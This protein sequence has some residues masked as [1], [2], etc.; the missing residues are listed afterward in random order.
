L[1]EIRRNFSQKHLVTLSSIA[2]TGRKKSHG[3]ER[4]DAVR[5]RLSTGSQSGFPPSRVSL[6]GRQLEALAILKWE[7]APPP[8]SDYFKTFSNFKFKKS[9]S[10]IWQ[11]VLSL[12]LPILKPNNFSTFVGHFTDIFQVVETLFWHTTASAKLI[13]RTLNFFAQ[14]IKPHLK[15]I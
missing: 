12:A 10:E 5:K 4:I 6:H 11:R 2:K 15:S 1:H 7:N 9:C 14:H 8:L 3:S 13:W